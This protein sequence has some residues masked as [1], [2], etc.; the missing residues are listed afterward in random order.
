MIT[1][2]TV[3]RLTEEKYILQC[4]RCY[5]KHKGSFWLLSFKRTDRR[6]L[7]P[8]ATV[9]KVQ[10]FS[11][12]YISPQDRMVQLG[13]AKVF[14]QFQVGPVAHPSIVTGLPEKPGLVLHTVFLQDPPPLPLQLLNP[15]LLHLSLLYVSFF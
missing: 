6:V 5:A 13:K 3:K 15:L 4:S 7:L 11:L 9:G 12:P 8:E 2:E 14:P 1:L 10:G